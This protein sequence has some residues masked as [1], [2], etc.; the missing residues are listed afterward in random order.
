MLK[1]KLV[2][3]T[4]RGFIWAGRDSWIGQFTDGSRSGCP[5]RSIGELSLECIV[6]EK[7]LFLIKEQTKWISFRENCSV[8]LGV[9]KCGALPPLGLSGDT[10]GSWLYLDGAHLCVVTWLLLA[11]TLLPPSLLSASLCLNVFL[12]DALY[13]WELLLCS[14]SLTPFLLACMTIHPMGD[15]F[16]CL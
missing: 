16:I 13:Y 3:T 2:H 1:D 4:I 12:S 11:G 8:L 9:G 6:W 5:Q 7:N 15:L 14:P 10:P